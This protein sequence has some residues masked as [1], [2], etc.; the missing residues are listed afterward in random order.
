MRYLALSLVLA[1]GMT[2]TGQAAEISGRTPTFH[3][4]VLPILQNRCQDCHR[5]GEAV[6]M[7][8]IGYQETR[9]WAKAMKAAVLSKKMPPWFADPSVGHFSNDRTLSQAEID[10]LVAWVDAGAPEGNVRDAPPR[11]QF[12][13]GWTIGKPDLILEMPN[14][15]EI[16]AKGVIEYQYVIIPTGLKE[17]RWVMASEVRPGDKS[18]MH[19][20]ITQLREPGSKWMADQAPGVLFVPPKGMR[21]NSDQRLVGGLSGYVPGQALPPGDFPRRGTLLK[22]GTDLVL[23]LHYTPNG[24][25]TTDRTKVGIIFA[26]EAPT[27]RLLGGNSAS[28]NFKIPP[29]DPDFKVEASST[30]QYDCDLVS[31]MP[32]AHLRGKSFEYRVTHPNGETETILRVPKYD[33]NW[34]L[35]YYPAKP[36]HLEKGSTVQV[37]ATFDNSVNNKYNPDAT[38]EVHWGEQT[39]EEMMMGY[40]SVVVAP[41]EGPEGPVTRGAA[42]RGIGDR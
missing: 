33:F 12:V 16:P 14:A 8:L 24:K 7:A 3:K 20:V 23:Q 15:M 41:G 18:V 27:S 6:P 40:F 21:G 32:H 29:G 34:Q 38:K 4:D 1:A 39:F 36:I 35:T 28:Y 31:M 30:M 17:D 22:A 5:P 9:P 19:H 26:K 11:R 42:T 2:V 13:E 10:T 37:L 25:A